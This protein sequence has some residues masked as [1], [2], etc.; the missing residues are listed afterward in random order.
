MKDVFNSDITYLAILDHET[1]MINFPY[2]DGDDMPP[3]KLGEGLTSRIIQS[4][5]SMLINRDVDI[6]AEYN[7]HG[8]QTNRETG[9][10][11]PGGPYS[12]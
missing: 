1:N 8:N 9:D 3:F 6:M 4:G 2:Q 12:C 5:E 10:F 11:L 7:K